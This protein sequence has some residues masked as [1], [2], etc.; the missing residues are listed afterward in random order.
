MQEPAA[1]DRALLRALARGEMSALGDL[2]DAHA[3]T[4]F[5]LLLAWGLGREQAE[6][7][8]GEVFLALADRGARAAEIRDVRAYLAGV[9]RHRMA[10][11]RRRQSREGDPPPGLVDEAHAPDG[12]EAV[13][14]RDALGRLPVQ[15]R[16]VVVLKVWHGLTFDEIG[17]ALGISPNTAASRYRYAI[18]KLRRELGDE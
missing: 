13:A 2:Y 10:R 17:R 8:L 12:A 18:Q 16:E 1:D 6:D 5:H 4:I 15:Q 9:A 14:V 7:L 11:L 3:Q